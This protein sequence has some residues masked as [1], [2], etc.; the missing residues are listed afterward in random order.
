MTNM[1]PTLVTILRNSPAS[2]RWLTRTYAQVSHVDYIDMIGALAYTRQ[3][4]GAVWT[5]LNLPRLQMKTSR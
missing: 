2:A 4:F 1:S 3:L 5:F